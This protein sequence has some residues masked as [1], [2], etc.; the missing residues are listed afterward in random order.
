MAELDCSKQASASAFEP[1]QE[2]RITPEMIAAGL[3]A[4]VDW[5]ERDDAHEANLVRDIY[6]A[7]KRTEV[8]GDRV[9]P[10]R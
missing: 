8:Q 3:K 7:M 4:W 5:F 2:I 9:V 10:T 6:R 1:S